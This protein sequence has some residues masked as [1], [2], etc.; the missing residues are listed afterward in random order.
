MPV[1][2]LG[3]DITRT[4]GRAAKPLVAV[5]L[6]D[7]TDADLALLSTEKGITAPSIKKI[8]ESHHALARALASGMKPAE[9]G[10]VTGYSPSRISILQADPAFQDLLTVY[11]EGVGEIYSDLHHKMAAMAVDVVEEMHE[12]LQEDPGEFTTNQLLEVAKTFADRTGHGP[13]TKTQNVNINVDLA[14][15]LESGRRRA[16]EMRMKLVTTSTPHGEE[17]IA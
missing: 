2:D 4:R 12:R 3:L 15:R 16:E 9:A 5:E 7:L 13:Q 17:P 6:R 8:R 1:V 10:L 14:T 11:R